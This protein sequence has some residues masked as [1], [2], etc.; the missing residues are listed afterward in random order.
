MAHAMIV[1]SSQQRQALKFLDLCICAIS[2][3]HPTSLHSAVLLPETI[4]RNEVV[5]SPSL[6]PLSSPMVHFVFQHTRTQNTSA[7]VCWMRCSGKV[8]RNWPPQKQ[9][10]PL[11]QQQ[12]VI[13]ASW[14]CCRPVPFWF[15]KFLLG[16]QAFTSKS[17]E[18][19]AQHCSE[20]LA[21]QGFVSEHAKTQLA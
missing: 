15:R 10:Q 14:V 2:G 17:Y 19:C 20:D 5:T 13:M 9:Q 4:Y 18:A 8:Q 6:D 7:I 12:Q 21:W 11:S 1:A 3:H 16:L